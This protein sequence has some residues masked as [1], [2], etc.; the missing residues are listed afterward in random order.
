MLLV[1]SKDFCDA[2]AAGSAAGF[3]AGFLAAG[4]AAGFLVAASALIEPAPPIASDSTAASAT[5]LILLFKRDP[6]SWALVVPG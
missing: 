1:I 6:F 5:D 2:A 3:A 4:F